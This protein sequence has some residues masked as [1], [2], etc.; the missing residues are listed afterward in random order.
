[1]ADLDFPRQ[2]AFLAEGVTVRDAGSRNGTLAPNGQRISA[3]YVLLPDQPIRLGACTLTLLRST[4]H[5]GGT[6]VM[7]ERPALPVRKAP[8]QPPAVPHVLLQRDTRALP[9]IARWIKLLGVSALLA[10]SLVSFRT[11]SA[12]VDALGAR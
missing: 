5:S 6:R 2:S 9:G 8:V 7:Q 12:L 3:S 1:M 11:C 4:G 10:L